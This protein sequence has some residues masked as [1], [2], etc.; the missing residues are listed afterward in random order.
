MKKPTLLA[1][2]ATLLT[3]SAVA[4]DNIITAGKSGASY[5]KTNSGDLW[6][7]SVLYTTDGNGHLLTM[8]GLSLASD[9]IT[10]PKNDGRAY[11]TDSVGRL[12][13]ASVAYT[14]DGNGNII[15][16]S[17]GGGG[18]AVTSVF[19]RTGVVAATGS[20]YSAFYLQLS[21]NL[22][23]LASA[24]TAR[25]NLGLG[26]AA[27]QPSSAFDA[28]GAAA[29]VGT[30]SLQKANNLS[31][32]AS[33]STA[34]TNLGLGSAATSAASAF[35][36]SGAAAS[37]QAA[38]LQKSSNLSDLAS[39]STAR[40]NLG[41]TAVATASTGNLTGS[42]PFSLTGG[43]GAVIGTGVSLGVASG[44]Y[45][46]TTTDQSTW[47]A[48]Q[49]ALT[50][51]NLTEATS[52]IL[53]ITGGTG[54]VIGSGLTLQVAQA[55]A[56]TSGYLGTAD[57]NT[58]N[59]KQAALTFTAPLVNTSSTISASAVG[60]DAGSGGTS[61]IVP[62]PA[63][64]TNEQGY[65]LGAGGAFV[66]NDTQKPLSP[67][68]Q[69]LSQALPPAGDQ[70]FANVLM[71]QNGA[72][73][74]AV[75]GGGTTETVAIYNVTDQAK[76]L[77]R[78]SINLSGTYGVCGTNASWPYVFVP[79]SGARTLTVLNISN[80]NSPTVVG[81]PF[82]WTANTTSIYACAYYNGLVFMAGQSHGLGILDVG[83]GVGGG[84][85]TAPVL[86]YDEGTQSICSVANSCKSFGVAVDPVNLIAYVSDFSTATPWTYRQLK[87][88][89]FSSSITS[90]TLLQN[91]TLPANTKAVGVGLNLG[92]KTAFVTDTNQ[93][94]VDVVDLTNVATGGMAYLST[95]TPTGGRTFNA[96]VVAAA[97]SGSN[98]VYVPSG[99]SALT[100]A[101]D[102][103]DLTNRATPIKVATAIANLTGVSTSV[104]GSLAIDPRG[105]YIYDG[106]YG[107]GTAGA[108]LD[109]FSMPY[110][111]AT[112][113][114]TTVGN[115][116]NTGHFKSNQLVPPTAT[117]NAT[118]AGTGATCAMTKATDT[119]GVVTL[120]TGTGVLG[121]GAQ[122][123][124][125][126]NN[127]FGVAPICTMTP[128]TSITALASVAP[129]LTAATTALT[130]NFSVAGALSTAYS[131]NYNCIEAQ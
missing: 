5:I 65:V 79:A 98:Y 39:A 34:R 93:N 86:V 1:L 44:F 55:G 111:V 12:F 17:G 60:G 128:N 103:F 49:A 4:S 84:T 83:N 112:F 28:A 26:S 57:W 13:P 25:T 109:I 20:D 75:A 52:S 42:S 50:F 110:E 38:S 18:G 14:T 71:M 58:F 107:N 123:A 101:L 82:S 69:M 48:K 74:Y 35:D 126:F 37:A 131:Y 62:A 120:T 23:D 24:S 81:T 6:P 68:F 89:S 9:I 90:P 99:G 117:V 53:T 15:P 77:L 56:S 119:A 100:G 27:T 105:G 108:G 64:G 51:G 11:L 2:F 7:A 80:P 30:A 97:V 3:M 66:A 47:N 45:F 40:T 63:S 78:G 43:A 88:Y 76:P 31:D 102:M 70:K 22:S 46:P 41:L 73:T 113:G 94:V 91:L 72:S 122:C 21:N 16:I 96:S 92:T 36:A 87:A 121:T 54:A 61:G 59:A 19:G 129:Y 104:F 116:I 125:N 114:A 8:G 67:P 33:A 127:A 29:A 106:D 124:V 85:I 95:L 32:L 115:L 118:N 130:L 10:V